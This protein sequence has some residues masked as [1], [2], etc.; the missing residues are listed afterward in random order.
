[1]P[2]ELEA[3]LAGVSIL[4]GVVKEAL[5]LV[6]DIRSGLGARNNQAKKALTEKLGRVEAS[7]GQVGE[8]AKAAEAYG[9]SLENVLELLWLCQRAERLVHDNSQDFGKKTS[10]NYAASWRVLDT[11]FETIESRSEVPRKAIMGLSAWYDERD[12]AQ[13][14]LLLNDFTAAFERASL[15]TRRRDASDLAGELEDMV[16]PLQRADTLLR[17]TVYDKILPTLQSLG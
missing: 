2:L 17:S 11:L 10:P 5:P 9:K 12:R 8:L 14:D 6:E 13:M 15:Y 7:L 4:R 3:V 16:K 1:M